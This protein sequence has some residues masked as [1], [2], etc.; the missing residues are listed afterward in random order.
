M[1]N[2]YVY[3][4]REDSWFLAD[5]ATEQ[6]HSGQVLEVGVGSGFVSSRVECETNADVVGSD[7]NP[8]ACQSAFDNR[9]ISSVRCNIADAFIGNSFDWVLF[10]SPYLPQDGLVEEREQ[11]ALTSQNKGTRVIQSFLADMSRVLTNTGRVL[12]LVSSRT[13]TERVDQLVQGNNFI[14]EKQY[15]KSLFFERLIVYEL[16]YSK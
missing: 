2:E 6:I 4:P 12:L 7:I 9:G 10:N 15:E 3:E 11:D 8:F 1:S 5:I 16:S 13:D 14:V